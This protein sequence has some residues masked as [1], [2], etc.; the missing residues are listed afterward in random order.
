MS[1]GRGGHGYGE[2][3]G[4]K[5]DLWTTMYLTPRVA[6]SMVRIQARPGQARSAKCR[7]VAGYHPRIEGPI[8]KAMDGPK[9]HPIDPGEAVDDDDDD[10]DDDF[11]AAPPPGQSEEEGQ[12]WGEDGD[13]WLRL[14]HSRLSGSPGT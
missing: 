2:S 12:L 13:G 4:G 9:R 1:I 8:R 10:D 6:V 3:V 11:K 7:I 14:N 5:K